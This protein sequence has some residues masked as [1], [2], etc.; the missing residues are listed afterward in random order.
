MAEIKLEKDVEKKLDIG[1]NQKIVS[2]TATLDGE[3]YSL[4]NIENDLKGKDWVNIP[5]FMIKIFEKKLVD[6]G[7]EYLKNFPTGCSKK[8]DGYFNSEEE[9]LLKERNTK[10]IEFYKS[11]VDAQRRQFFF[12]QQGVKNSL[13]HAQKLLDEFGKENDYITI[14]YESTTEK[15]D[16]VENHL[17]EENA[18]N[19]QES[20]ITEK[21]KNLIYFGAP[22]TG[23]SY[24]L[25]QLAS[26]FK[27]KVERV[28]FHPNYSYA[29]FVGSY[30]PVPLENNDNDI[31]YKFVPGPFIRKLVDAMNSPE[32]Q[33]LIIEEINR[34]NPAAVF[35]DVFQLLDRDDEGKS[36]YYINPSEDLRKH[37]RGKLIDKCN[38]CEKIEIPPN[39]YIWATMNSADQGVF[40]MDTA[41]KRR[42]DFEYI[43]ID[44][45]EGALKDGSW[46][47]LRKAIN[48]LL[49]GLGVNE[50]KLIG[51]FF[52]GSN[53][54]LDDSDDSKKKFKNKLLMYL[55]EDAGR[56]KRA[57]LFGDS[58]ITLS[59][60][61]K[62]YDDGKL[63]HFKL[64]DSTD[65]D[66]PETLEDENGPD[67]TEQT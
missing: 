48:N 67:E 6:K 51:P 35:G 14:T 58:N 20:K 19:G 31:T 64:S 24:K 53:F 28:T 1:T 49:K 26:E 61:F 11:H 23:K 17:K 34:A 52:L 65:A 60:V 56:F 5:K 54:K 47:T 7:E 12:F 59:E 37:L 13:Q 8:H 66:A 25:D 15:N 45:G 43:G 3:N 2:L 63:K 62:N 21:R 27:T 18:N 29:Q 44:D 57:E 41:F 33:L 55:F 32:P 36:V 38:N 10:G 39:L 42:W 9:F 16:K 22:G 30:K 46:N 40:P 4:E 50:D